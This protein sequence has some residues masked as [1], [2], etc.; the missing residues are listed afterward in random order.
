MR[1]RVARGAA[2]HRYQGAAVPEAVRLPAWRGRAE[3]AT[4]KLDAWLDQDAEAQEAAE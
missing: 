1:G 4:A 2:S 3:A